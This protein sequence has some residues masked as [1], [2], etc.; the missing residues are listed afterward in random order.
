MN[1]KMSFEEAK[2]FWRWK[3]KQIGIKIVAMLFGIWVLFSLVGVIIFIGHLKGTVETPIIYTAFATS[4]IILLV[5]AGVVGVTSL[6]ETEKK[7]SE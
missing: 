5:V 4:I 3:W 2:K 1:E 6:L 7:E